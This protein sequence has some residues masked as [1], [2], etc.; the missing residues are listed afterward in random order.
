MKDRLVL[1]MAYLIIQGSEISKYSCD[2][3]DNE[4]KGYE[5]CVNG[6]GRVR[7][8]ARVTTALKPSVRQ[9]KHQQQLKLAHV[10]VFRNV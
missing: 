1:Y 9:P 3:S 6:T 4:R 5:M 2:C 7:Q 8:S 10:V